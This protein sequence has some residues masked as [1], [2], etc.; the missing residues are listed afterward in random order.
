MVF[1]L[2]SFMA[3]YERSVLWEL[4]L[5]KA[6]VRPHPLK[7]VHFWW[8]CF[9]HRR[10]K[11]N[12]PGLAS[13]TLAQGQAPNTNSSPVEKLAQALLITHHTGHAPSH[14]SD[15]KI[16]GFILC[17]RPP[18]H[19]RLCDGAVLGTFSLAA[20]A[21][22]KPRAW[23]GRLEKCTS[24]CCQHPVPQKQAAAAVCWG[25]SRHR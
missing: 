19:C 4:F 15:Q 17:T 3:S 13:G 6:L 25:M 18:E 14:C 11:I 2:C 12:Y 1:L 7:S 21:K 23:S 24:L 22:E 10:G 20:Q 5:F 16:G 8:L 9:Q